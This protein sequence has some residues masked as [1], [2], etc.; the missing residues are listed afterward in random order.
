MKNMRNHRNK[1]HKS[2]LN[3]SI[4]L[5]YQFFFNLL[6]YFQFADLAGSASFCQKF[7]IVKNKNI[8]FLL[9]LILQLNYFVLF[10]FTISER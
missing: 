4:T 10:Y 9:L 7:L 5:I 8:F 2:S 1:K 6:E 3:F